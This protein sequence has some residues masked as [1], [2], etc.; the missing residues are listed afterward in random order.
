MFKKSK[1]PVV[2]SDQNSI[3]K[4]TL[5]TR[6]PPQP[7][8]EISSSLARLTARR[9]GLARTPELASRGARLRS[10]SARFAFR[11]L[12]SLQP[13]APSTARR[14]PRFPPARSLPRAAS[15]PLASL[16]TISCGRLSLTRS[17][18]PRRRGRRDRH[19]RSTSRGSRARTV[20]RRYRGSRAVQGRTT[21]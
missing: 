3:D 12:R 11:S 20:S 19:P 9:S 5:R 6:R 8:S 15:C 14:A 7:S 13:L 18:A 21:G 16:V 10:R 2:A 1:E 4:V 17:G